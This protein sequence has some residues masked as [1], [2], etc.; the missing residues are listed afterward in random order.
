MKTNSTI[1]TF[2]QSCL[3]GAGAGF[4]ILELQAQQPDGV[5]LM[6][7]GA[8]FGTGMHWAGKGLSVKTLAVAALMSAA[9]PVI[10]GVMLL[11]E[12]LLAAIA[13][14]LVGLSL[15]MTLVGE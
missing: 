3:M 2:A 1:K 11:H 15:R 13:A 8:L 7:C 5:V 9:V 12:P 10:A 14:V 6:I 4:G